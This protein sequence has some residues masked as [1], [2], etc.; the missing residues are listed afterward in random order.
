MD[1]KLQMRIAMAKVAHSL[2]AEDHIAD[3]TARLAKIAAVDEDKRKVPFGNDDFLIRKHGQYDP[4]QALD[5]IEG[6]VAKMYH[7]AREEVPEELS[8]MVRS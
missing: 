8:R 6:E 2:F 7:D 5:R 4:D 3:M 1:S